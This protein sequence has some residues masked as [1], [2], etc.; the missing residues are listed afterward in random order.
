M[1]RARQSA[2]SLAN[3]PLPAGG[4]PPP[5]PPGTV[6]DDMTGGIPPTGNPYVVNPNLPGSLRYIDED[7]T[8][9]QL[10]EKEIICDF[11]TRE[12]LTKRGIIIQYLN[13]NSTGATTMIGVTRIGLTDPRRV[14]AFLQRNAAIIRQHAVAALQVHFKMTLCSA[15]VLEKLMPEDYSISFSWASITEAGRSL[16]L[17]G[18]P[19]LALGYGMCDQYVQPMLASRNDPHPVC[20]LNAF[21]QLQ[22]PARRSTTVIKRAR[23]EAAQK[24]Q[25]PPPKK[26]APNYN[27]NYR[28]QQ[29]PINEDHTAERIAS[30]A[31]DILTENLKRAAPVTLDQYFPQLQAGEGPSWPKEGKMPIPDE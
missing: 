2:A 29:Q 18:K 24:A 22:E 23:E 11:V 31:T 20:V 6:D 4:Q 9:L 21:I 1:S 7:F 26:H 8:L 15:G 30:K 14:P 10:K 25:G 16:T 17:H 3:P 19:D 12:M 28:G 13:S 27:P 5:P